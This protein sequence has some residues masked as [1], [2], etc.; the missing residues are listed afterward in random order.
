[1]KSITNQKNIKV[2]A[3]FIIWGCTTG[4][5][6][7]CIPLVSASNIGTILPLAVIIGASASTISVWISDH[8]EYYKRSNNLQQIE[9]RI[10]NLETICTQEHN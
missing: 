1:M 4:I 6:A 3:T 10:I 8:Q 2:E 7:I 9:Q 5:M